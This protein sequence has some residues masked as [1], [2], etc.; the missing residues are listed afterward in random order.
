MLAG[1]SVL[2]LLSLP[3]SSAVAGEFAAIVNGKSFHIGASEDWNENNLGLGLE[4]AFATKS[5][6]RPRLMANGFRDSSDEMSYMLGGSLH[7]NLVASERLSGLYLDAGIN[8]FLMSRED[9][10]NNEPFPGVLPSIAIGNRF[11]GFNL[12]Y[13]PRKAVEKFLSQRIA[14]DTAAGIIY[15]QLKIALKPRSAD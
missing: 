3:F 7:R 12:T 8:A 10:N 13:L 15:L 2:A 14:D 4:Y 11:G 1:L 5:R 6:W 9:V